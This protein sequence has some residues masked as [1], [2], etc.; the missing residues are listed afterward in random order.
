M[1]DLLEQSADCSPAREKFKALSESILQTV[2]RCRTIT[3]RLLGFARRLEVA[4]EMLDLN[5]V[6][7]DVLGFLEKEALYR[8]IA[9]QLSLAENLPQIS[10]DR[11]QLQQVFLNVLTNAFAAVE[12]GGHVSITTRDENPETIGVS[13]QDDGCGMSEETLRHI[14]EPFFTTKKGYGTGLGL[15]ITYGIVKKLGGAFKV[16]SKEGLGT[17]L[18]VFIPKLPQRAQED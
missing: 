6:I 3:H 15:P 1:K 5:D 10:S 7:R 18:T 13:I 17:T 2:N 14:F 16:E 4:F 8:K 12:D 9:I 11:G